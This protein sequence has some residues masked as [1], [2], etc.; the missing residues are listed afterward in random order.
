M[1]KLSIFLGLLFFANTVS[2]APKDIFICQNN[3]IKVAVSQAGKK[4][5]RYTQWTTSRSRPVLVLHGKQMRVEGE[6]ACA[7]KV[8]SFARPNGW[9]NEVYVFNPKAK[10]DDGKPNPKGWLVVTRYEQ[11]VSHLNCQ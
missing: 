1:K 4:G 8:Y 6:G 3:K 5:Y 10:C 7:Y 2:A 9:L 11:D